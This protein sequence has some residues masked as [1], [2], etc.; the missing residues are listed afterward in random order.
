MSENVG[1]I[2]DCTGC[3]ACYN[4]CP[5]D[6]IR[7]SPSGRGG[8]IR[9]FVDA[10]RCI[11]CGLCLKACPEYGESD[12]HYPL[13][14]FAARSRDMSDYVTSSSGGIASVLSSYIVEHGG[15]VYGCC[16]DGLDFRHARAVTEDG[17]RGFKGSKYVQSSMHDM[18][19]KVRGDLSAGLTVLFI[20]TPCQV[21]GLKGYI[22]KIPDRLYLVDLVCHGV[23]SQKMLR[24]HIRHIIGD[25]R[26]DS[27]TFRRGSR[28]ELAIYSSGKAVYKSEFWKNSFEDMYYRAFFYGISYRDSCYACRFAGPERGADIT[29]G[30]FWGINDPDRLPFGAE[31]GLSLA[32]PVTDKGLA[33][34]N[35]VGD[36]IF[37]E[38]R[39]VGEAVAGNPQLRHPSGFTMRVRLFRLLHGILPFDAAVRM[40]FAD[41]LLRRHL[42]ALKHK[43]LRR[44][45]K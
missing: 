8:H 13:K 35:A 19:R 28:F 16:P 9:P 42:Y 14:A 23:P 33:L 37:M 36:R 26:A 34:L 7:M 22:G 32:M 15:A 24:E 38:E 4:A 25:E 43:M 27:V 5:A 31:D 39:P 30:D 2:R 6:C 21:A 12:L 11:G 40:A 3:W 10:G 1:I 20:G 45:A 41:K 29:I 17:L 18:F 44:D